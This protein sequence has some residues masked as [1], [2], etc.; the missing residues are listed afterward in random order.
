V[1]RRFGF[2]I[3]LNFFGRIITRPFFTASIRCPLWGLLRTFATAPCFWFFIVADGHDEH[4]I[5]VLF[6]NR[7][8]IKVG[9]KTLWRHRAD[10]Q[11][12]CSPIPKASKTAPKPEALLSRF[13]CIAA[14]L[15]MTPVL[16]SVCSAIFFAYSQKR[17]LSSS[18]YC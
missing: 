1:K 3:S 15:M 10:R 5:R 4:N 14:S 13:D 7:L 16:M 17:A 9:Q 8:N 12:Q 6:Q 2:T 18:M 11:P